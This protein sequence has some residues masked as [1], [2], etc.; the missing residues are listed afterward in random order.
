[1]VFIWVVGG[2]KKGRQ[3]RETFGDKMKL[4]FCYLIAFHRVAIFGVQETLSPSAGENGDLDKCT[5]FLAVKNCVII[6]CNM[7]YFFFLS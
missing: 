2:E 5:R 7:N 1:M 4:Y 6:L 3:E